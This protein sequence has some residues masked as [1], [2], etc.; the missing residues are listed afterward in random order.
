[1][2]L[3]IALVI[4]V[5]LFLWIFRCYVVSL[6]EYLLVR[7]ERK[8]IDFQLLSLLRDDLVHE[9]KKKMAGLEMMLSSW[10]RGDEIQPKYEYFEELL[11][12]LK[13]LVRD[14]RENLMALTKDIFLW[15][16]L[17][18][19][20]RRIEKTCR[21]KRER[22][23]IRELRNELG[24]IQNLI[25]KVVEGATEKFSFTLNQV[26]SESVKIVQIEKSQSYGSK[27]GL[28][29]IQIF[30]QLDDAGNSIRFSYDKF[31]DWQRILTNLI[32][33]AIEAV[34]AKQWEEGIASRFS[35]RGG[36][37]NVVADLGLPGEEENLWVKVSTKETVSVPVSVSNSVSVCIEDSGIGMDEITRSSFYKKGFTSGKEGGLGLGVNEESVQLINQYGNWEIESQKG[38][39]T[40]IT[41]NIDK[42]KARKAELILPPKKPFLRTKLAYSVAFL[43]LVLIGLTLL[44]VF[45]KYSRFWVDWNSSYAE[46]KQGRQ[47]F[48]Y[49]KDGKE[50]WMHEFERSVGIRETAP[51]IKEPFISIVDLD[52]DGWN[53]ILVSIAYD[54]Q[55]PAKLFC[56][57]H[58]GKVKWVFSAGQ[59]YNDETG[60]D[61]SNIKPDIFSIKNF[62]IDFFIDSTKKEILVQSQH[63]ALFPCQLAMLD[64]HG[65]V[66]GEYWHPGNVPFLYYTDLDSDGKKELVCAGINNRL[67]WQPVF[68]T[69]KVKELMGSKLQGP[70]Y[71]VFGNV[72]PAKEKKY[73][74]LPQIKNVDW[75]WVEASPILTPKSM[76][77]RSD[78][79][80]LMLFDGRHYSLTKDLQYR[81]C[82]FRVAQFLYWQKCIKFPYEVNLEID[83]LNWSNFEIYESGIRVK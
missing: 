78:D 79:I 16:K 67:N 36:D 63:F 47:V 56:L 10:E 52:Q 18:H 37:E 34:E 51:G 25:D 15:E 38:V 54:I 32:R 42:E 6:Y 50:L 74:V 8:K 66:I 57:D 62:M 61:T 71:N 30:E 26:V 64:Y 72:K 29:D 14:H 17:W 19:M 60:I 77:I 46:V 58:E 69:L 65:N 70:P 55:T 24:R 2:F 53:E 11:D 49:N 21:E 59:G 13:D 28:K 43:L 1:M 44:F 83:S 39:G 4:A 68:F 75:T 81:S 12:Q 23:E 5:S 27:V 76:N 3:L 80:F 73:V 35:V 45:D 22:V 41:I 9:R 7:F 33:N 20:L 82:E 31:K 40:K 48:V